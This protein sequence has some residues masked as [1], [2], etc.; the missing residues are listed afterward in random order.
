MN[1]EMETKEKWKN[2]KIEWKKWEEK[3]NKNERKRGEIKTNEWKK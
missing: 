1:R 2:M 3:I